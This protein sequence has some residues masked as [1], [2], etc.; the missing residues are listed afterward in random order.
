M[1]EGAAP[2]HWAASWTAGPPEPAWE[3]CSAVPH[4]IQVM[5]R[6]GECQPWVVTHCLWRG[7]FVMPMASTCPALWAMPCVDACTNGVRWPGTDWHGPWRAAAAPCSGRAANGA[8]RG[9]PVAG[10]FEWRGGARENL[11]KTMAALSPCSNECPIGSCC[12][13]ITGFQRNSWVGFP[14]PR[15]FRGGATSCV[16]E[17]QVDLLLLM[18]IGACVRHWEQRCCPW[19]AITMA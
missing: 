12:G 13:G 10:H 9:G 18:P 14:S 15:Y 5:A 6:M 16:W 17:M 4:A 7:R 2:A 8:S 19:S 11:S 1:P 3:Q